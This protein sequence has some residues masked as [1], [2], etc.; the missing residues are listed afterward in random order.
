MGVVHLDFALDYR[1]AR[2]DRTFGASRAY[3]AQ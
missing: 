1:T 3:K 2:T